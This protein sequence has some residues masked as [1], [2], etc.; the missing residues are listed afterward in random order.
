MG[1]GV[2][3]FLIRKNCVP[4][5]LPPRQAPGTVHRRHSMSEQIDGG[6]PQRLG[7]LFPYLPANLY[8]SIPKI[9][10]RFSC[11][12]YSLGT[13]RQQWERCGVSLDLDLCPLPFI[14]YSFYEISFTPMASVLVTP[15]FAFPSQSSSLVYLAISPRLNSQLPA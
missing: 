8:L 13:C 12:G 6:S 11:W 7:H 14:S 10:K 5:C 1:T 4:S 3:S 15:K 2:L 9:K